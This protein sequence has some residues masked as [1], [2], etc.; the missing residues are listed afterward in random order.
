M[1]REFK[2]KCTSCGHPNELKLD[3]VYNRLLCER[4]NA[5]IDMDASVTLE[6]IMDPKPVTLRR[7]TVVVGF[8]SREDGDEVKCS[9]CGTEADLEFEDVL[10]SCS[11]YRCKKCGNVVEVSPEDKPTD[12]VCA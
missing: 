8:R 6:L 5:E 2:V 1:G 3:R 11:R 9:A 10:G 12:H 7:D 4:C